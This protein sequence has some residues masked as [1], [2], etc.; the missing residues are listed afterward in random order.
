VRSL[1]TRSVY[2]LAI[3]GAM[4]G[5]SWVLMQGLAWTFAG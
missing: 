2:L 1:I 5:W 3:T 4:L